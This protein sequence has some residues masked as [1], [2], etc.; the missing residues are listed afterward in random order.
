MIFVGLVFALLSVWFKGN[1]E[2]KFST[3]SFKPPHVYC[4]Y[5][6]L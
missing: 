6:L 4:V 1:K 3:L 5:R 2:L